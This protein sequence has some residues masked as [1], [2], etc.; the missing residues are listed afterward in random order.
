MTTMAPM[1]IYNITD[2]HHQYNYLLLE[3]LTFGH[4]FVN[5]NNKEPS[6]K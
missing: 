2:D 3:L 1:L 5:K 4:N 6:V